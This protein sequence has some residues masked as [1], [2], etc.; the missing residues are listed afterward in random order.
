MTSWPCNHSKNN[1]H[2]FQVGDH[3]KLIFLFRVALGKNRSAMNAK[4]DKKMCYQIKVTRM[5][6]CRRLVWL[7]V[8]GYAFSAAGGNICCSSI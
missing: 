8:V 7:S 5:S 3:P 4:L 1:T 2:G 6:W